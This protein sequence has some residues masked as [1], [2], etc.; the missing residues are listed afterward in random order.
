M[1]D[2]A[3]LNFERVLDRQRA[4]FG[5]PRDQPV[6]DYI[7]NSA[8]QMHELSVMDGI[9]EAQ[10]RSVALSDVVQVPNA[11]YHLRFGAGRRLRMM[12]T[13]WR[14]V[15]GIAGDGR[16]AP[17]NSE[18]SDELTE[19]VNL[20]Y[21]NIRGVLDNLV[22]ALLYEHAPETAA[23][24]RPAAIGLF[25]PGIVNDQRFTDLAHGLREHE[26]WHVDV[27]N[28]RDPAAHRIPLYVPSQVVTPDEAEMREKLMGESWA[29]AAR[30]E[31]DVAE[32][33]RRQADALGTFHPVISHDPDAGAIALFPTLPDDLGH[34]V[35]VFIAVD[36]FLVQKA[37]GR[38]LGGAS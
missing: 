24:A 34:V 38:V 18:E 32:N 15:M 7:V 33:S 13:G 25:A 27:K 37:A 1:L 16:T 29:A 10:W 6:P 23:T 14:S 4:Q 30:K 8:H 20:L 3:G 19:A 21:I 9:R 26:G 36:A 11:R 17:L 12:W 22:W 31:F 2:V 28:R 35:E 5:I